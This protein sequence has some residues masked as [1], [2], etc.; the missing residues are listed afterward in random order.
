MASVIAPRRNQNGDL[1]IDL[2]RKNYTAIP[3][4]V[5][6]HSNIDVLRLSENR[7]TILPAGISSFKT[8][9]VLE[10]R[11]NYLETFPAPILELQLLRSLDLSFNKLTGVSK[12]IKG[13]V[14]LAILQLSNNK[15]NKFPEEVCMLKKLEKLDINNCRIDAIPASIAQLQTLSDLDVSGNQV[16]EVSEEIYG[17]RHLRSLNLSNNKLEILPPLLSIKLTK[18]GELKLVGNDLREPPRDVCERGL[19]EVKEYQ[20]QQQR[21]PRPV[22][23][24]RPRSNIDQQRTKRYPINRGL[25]AIV[26]NEK[27]SVREKRP[28]SLVDRDKIRDAFKKHPFN[29]KVFSDLTGDEMLY[30]LKLLCKLDE[31]IDCLIIFLLTHATP[32]AALG[33]DGKFICYKDVVETFSVDS[34]PRLAGKPKVFL[35]Q[36]YQSDARDVGQ[37]MLPNEDD[38]MFGC[39]MI[40]TVEGYRAATNA[41]SPYIESV[42]RFIKECGDTNHMT[43]IM[44]MVADDM[45]TKSFTVKGKQTKMRTFM[46][47]T[48]TR[49]LWLK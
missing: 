11:K 4:D 33:I 45:K 40:P 2:C 5:F 18:L 7:L 24:S 9:R 34:C 44:T 32:S 48:L 16:T 42:C 39:A 43:E 29:V 19:T 37:F 47:G 22:V 46:L 15:F 1:I 36:G 20:Q 10:L 49:Q 13:L 41:S 26:C 35:Q 23:P 6:T 27:Y 8:L 14:N 3:A 21:A 12:G 28:G 31:D 30:T 25:V 38:F 17:N